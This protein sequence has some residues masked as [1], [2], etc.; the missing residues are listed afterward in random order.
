MASIFFNIKFNDAAL[1][2]SV[3]PLHPQSSGFIPNLLN[4][5]ANVIPQ[6]LIGS[7]NVLKEDKPRSESVLEARLVSTGEFKF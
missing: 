3:K 2:G 5:T 6:N 1:N 4:A 7:S